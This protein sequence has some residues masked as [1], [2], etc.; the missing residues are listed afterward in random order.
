MAETNKNQSIPTVCASL[1]GCG[2]SILLA[3]W[4]GFLWGMDF[5]E[6][7]ILVIGSIP[8]ITIAIN[9]LFKYLYE[10]FLMGAGKRSFDRSNQQKLQRLRTA[11]NDPLVDEQSK[12]EFQKQYTEAIQ[13]SI[14]I[15][16]INVSVQAIK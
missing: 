2:I 9:K 3:N 12:R 11:L 8:A 15:K 6:L 7:K 16:D 13:A 14:N 1:L 5:T 10:R 4:Q